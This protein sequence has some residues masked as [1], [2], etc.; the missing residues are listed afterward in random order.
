MRDRVDEGLKITCSGCEKVFL[1][2]GAP[3]LF[4]EL[5]LSLIS[6]QRVWQQLQYGEWKAY[7]QYSMLYG[8]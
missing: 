5:L 7:T 6:D 1:R 4:T 8:E 2:N 3:I